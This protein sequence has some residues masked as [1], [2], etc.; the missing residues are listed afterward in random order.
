MTAWLEASPENQALFDR[1][2][3]AWQFAAPQPMPTLPNAREELVR[4][5]SNLNTPPQRAHILSMK[6]PINRTARWITAAAAILLIAF[7]S[8]RLFFADIVVK[9]AYGES[10]QVVLPDGS[11][12]RLN[13]GSRLSWPR[14]FDD[15]A[16][17]VQ[18]AGEAFFSVKKGETPFVVT[19]DNSS[20]RV[21][22]TEF[23]VRARRHRTTLVVRKG[24]VA[25][26]SRQKRQK[27]IVLK[28]NQMS[29]CNTQETPAPVT[30]VDM[31]SA[32]GWMLG[33]LTF[34]DATLN[35]VTDEVERIYNVEIDVAISDFNGRVSG[36]FKEK[37]AEQVLK[38][39][40]VVHGLKV[41]NQGGVYIIER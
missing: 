5:R 19:T 4:L 15:K 11:T 30:T 3:A 22:G 40:C 36:S 21:L 26:A 33:L 18:L 27:E 10:R 34:Q 20:I 29:V 14:R 37:S 7:G 41:T 23:N 35:D 6:F 16:R 1:T 38:A 39:V 25:F 9:T 32:L 2:A 24:I 28:A 17:P 31:E 12:V 8:H 13:A